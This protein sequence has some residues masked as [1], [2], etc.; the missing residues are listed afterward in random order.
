MRAPFF[1]R[2]MALI[3]LPHI[4]T[5]FLCGFNLNLSKLSSVIHLASRGDCRG[6]PEELRLG[7][8]YSVTWAKLLQTL[9]I[10]RKWLHILLWNGRIKI[11]V[12]DPEQVSCNT[13][14]RDNFTLQIRQYLRL[15]FTSK[16]RYFK[17]IRHAK[18]GLSP[19]AKAFSFPIPDKT[20][21]FIL[22]A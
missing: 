21:H 9:A 10:L 8:R 22:P 11:Y 3:S 4:N 2:T 20:F 17:S 1:L 15:A 5:T 16:G 13:N 18:H 6:A 19:L 7:K 12:R 14:F